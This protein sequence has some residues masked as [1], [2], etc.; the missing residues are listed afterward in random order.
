[1]KKGAKSNGNGWKCAGGGVWRSAVRLSGQEFHQQGLHTQTERTVRRERT[2]VDWDTGFGH[3]V[4][5]INR[6]CSEL[7]V[8]LECV[9]VA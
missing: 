4:R 9:K 5:R 2:A 1:V 3:A 8:P 6:T 7:K